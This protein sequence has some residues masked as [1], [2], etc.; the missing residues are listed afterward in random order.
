MRARESEHLR[1]SSGKGGVREELL[2]LEICDLHR[3]RN[4]CSRPRVHVLP[5]LKLN[6]F[7]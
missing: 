1:D 6:H 2:F 7:V 3:D 4:F 5:I